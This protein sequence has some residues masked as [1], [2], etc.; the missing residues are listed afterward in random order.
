MQI[1]EE[2]QWPEDSDDICDQCYED[3]IRDVDVHIIDT[4][5]PE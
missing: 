1:Y 4:D 5:N 2:S 3:E